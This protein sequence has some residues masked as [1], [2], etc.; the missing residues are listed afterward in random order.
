[1]SPTDEELIP[2][3]SGPFVHTSELAPCSALAGEERPRDKVSRITSN[4]CS[5]IR[6]PLCCQT[7]TIRGI[8]IDKS[9]LPPRDKIPRGNAFFPVHLSM[10]SLCER[11]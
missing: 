6:A 11:H 8:Q 10:T 7:F 9:Q 5:V 3:A 1:M 2:N 4:I